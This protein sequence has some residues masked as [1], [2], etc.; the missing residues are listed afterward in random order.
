M[1]S[2]FTNNKSIRHE[3]PVMQPNYKSS[4]TDNVLT[5]KALAKEIVLHFKPTGFIL[6]PCKG[7]G[8]FYD[9]FPA[10]KDWCEIK[11]GRDFFNYSG[12]V[13][14]IITNPPYSIFN[15]FLEKAMEI[16]SEIVFLIPV[17]KI[18]TS[19][20]RMEIITGWGGVKEILMIGRGR[21]IGFPFGFLCGAV[22]FSKGFNGATIIRWL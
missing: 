15:P 12:K 4:D 19:K 16:A 7:D 2:N 21:E 10:Q 9:C 14:W 6:D 3:L 20:K 11:L 18:W 13:D 1:Q 5:N 17:G 8:A 22:H